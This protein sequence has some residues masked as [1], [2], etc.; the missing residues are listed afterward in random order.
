[1]SEQVQPIVTLGK[2]AEVAKNSEDADSMVTC[3]I[4]SI[5][6]QAIQLGPLEFQK[7]LDNIIIQF[8]FHNAN[9]IP[10]RLCL[11]G[12]KHIDQSRRVGFDICISQ[13]YFA[14]TRAQ[15]VN[16]TPPQ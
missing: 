14:V 15:A 3:K 5:L 13:L 11:I 10:Q 9:A 6:H 1:M 4:S 16:S 12:T 2:E 7:Q 8:P